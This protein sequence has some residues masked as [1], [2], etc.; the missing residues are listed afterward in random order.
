MKLNNFF[1][2]LL[3]LLVSGACGQPSSGSDGSFPEEKKPLPLEPYLFPIKPGQT[4]QLA[5][6]MAEFRNSHL[7]GGIDIRTNNR[8][9]IPVR[10]TQS[11]YVERVA[12]K[13]SGY[14]LLLVMRHPDGNSSWYAHLDGYIKKLSDYVIRE[15]KAKQSNEIEI[16]FAPDQFEVLRGDTIAFSG[17]TGQSEGAHL[18]FEIRNSQNELINPLQ[19]GF[20]EIEDHVHPVAQKLALRCMN[21]DSRINHRFNREELSPVRHGHTYTAGPISA[22]G[23][24]GL[25]I[26]AVDYLIPGAFKCGINFIEMYHDGVKLFSRTIQ[27]FP[28]QSSTEM[29]NVMDV[30]INLKRHRKFQKLYIDD[31]NQM[32]IFD[33]SLGNGFI[34]IHEGKNVIT[35]LLKDFAGNV[36]TVE[37]LLTGVAPMQTVL[38]FKKTEPGHWDIF[39]N[40]LKLT[41]RPSFKEIDVHTRDTIQKLQPAYANSQYATYLIDM[42]KWPDSIITNSKKIEL[43]VNTMIPSHTPFH[44]T[45]PYLQIDFAPNSLYDTLYLKTVSQGKQFEIGNRYMVLRQPVEITYSSDMITAEPKQ[46]VYANGMYCGGS[47]SPGRVTFTTGWLGKFQIL[48]DNLPPVSRS[49]HKTPYSFRCRISDNLSGLA[50]YNGYIDGEWVLMYFDQ[51]SGKLSLHPSEITKPVGG[52]LELVLEDRAGNVSTCKYVLGPVQKNKNMR[53]VIGKPAPDFTI[54]DETGNPVTLSGY[55]GKKVVLYFYPKDQTPGCTEEA[56]NLRDNYND[57]LSK[58]YVIFGIST[59]SEESHR[60]FIEKEKL[61]FHLLADVNKIVHMKYHT[62]VEKQMFGKKYLGTARVTFVINEEGIIEDIIEK[63]NTKDHSSQILKP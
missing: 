46:A 7:H 18:H 40:T 20:C 50:K 53:P 30:E 41:T 28:H 47:F 48:S 22:H 5:G 14:G 26:L 10:A 33:R 51:K 57:L 25:E 12:V 9:G 60:K 44:F 42:R 63:V 13:A 19:F 35:I 21:A 49:V 39:K 38:P 6:T 36:T 4:G 16:T 43:P 34:K 31:G 58:G 3:V 56:C 8:V 27:A 32:S 62:W 11:G 52:T 37:A 55:R 59:D 54:N 17:D 24:L 45:N 29:N 61:P 15:Q 2:I 23:L 1:P